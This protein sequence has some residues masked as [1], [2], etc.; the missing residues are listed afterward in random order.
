MWSGERHQRIQRLLHRL[1]QVSTET[2]ARELA[3]SRETIR[4][5][6][7]DLERMGVLRRAHGGALLPDQQPEAPF[8][9]RLNVHRREK[10]AIARAAAKLIRSGQSVFLG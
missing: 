3:V 6:L 5:D 8:A 10:E 1:K 7:L 9:S 4:R 2:L